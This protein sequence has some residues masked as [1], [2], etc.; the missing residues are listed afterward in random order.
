MMY[1]IVFILER[2]YT[3]KPYISPTVVIITAHAAVL[4]LLAS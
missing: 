2:Y 3:Y 4:K 1:D